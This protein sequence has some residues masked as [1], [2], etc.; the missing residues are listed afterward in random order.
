M[1]LDLSKGRLIALGAIA[2][3]VIVLFS[4]TFYVVDQRTQ[5]LVLRLGDPVRVVNTP[6]FP[7]PGLHIK[8]PFLEEVVRFD[9]R[10]LAL[11]TQPEEI[12]ASDQGRLV[13]DAFVRYR[14][15]DPLQFY[16]ALRDE[17]TATD[18]LERLTNSSLREALGRATT[19]EIIS[20]RRA[21][22]MQQIEADVARRA[23]ASRYGVEVLDLRI[24]RADLP[25]ANRDAVYRRM[26]SDRQREAATLRA[27]GEREA[28]RI[29]ADATKLGDTIR[30]EGDAERA[31]IFADSFGKDASF[32][33]FFRSMQAYE[34]SLGQG[35]T[36]MVLS[37]DSAFFRYFSKGG[38]G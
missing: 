23:A 33:A 36:T 15:A 26:A 17:A 29:R 20:G 3:G 24:W 4:N 32:A 35:D 38:G 11:Q 12:I 6:R 22:L 7:S 37:P 28:A 10:N 27:T 19:P 1:N 16:R 13:V 21:A 2:L 25:E 18:R 30:G 31:K 5:A 9:K 14:I 8:T 34:A